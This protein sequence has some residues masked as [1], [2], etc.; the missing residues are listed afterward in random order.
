MA[1]PDGAGGA[2]D[3]SFATRT[4][5]FGTPPTH[6]RLSR[7]RSLRPSAVSGWLVK[8]K[9]RWPKRLALQAPRPVRGSVAVT[10]PARDLAPHPHPQRIFG[11]SPLPSPFSRLSIRHGPYS[12]VPAASGG[13]ARS[14]RPGGSQMTLAVNRL[15]PG[16]AGGSGFHP[17]RGPGRPPGGHRAGGVLAIFTLLKSTCPA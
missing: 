17:G 9:P 11:L 13:T 10:Q 2:G 5:F 12:G 7:V 16:A 3:V 6:P 8:A 1:A 15:L 4:A 14:C